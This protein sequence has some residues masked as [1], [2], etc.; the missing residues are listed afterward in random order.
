MHGAR[1]T[2]LGRQ[3]VGD[4]AAGVLDLVAQMAEAAGATGMQTWAFVPLGVW[5]PVDQNATPSNVPEVCT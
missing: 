2:K 1:V 3:G 5:E 4:N